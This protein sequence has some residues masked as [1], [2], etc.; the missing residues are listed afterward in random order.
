MIMKD[1][2]RLI[3]TVN[4][5][6]EEQ[7]S[8]A[9]SVRAFKPRYYH[10]S[11]E[12]WEKW[13]TRTSSRHISAKYELLQTR[14]ERP[15]SPINTLAPGLSSSPPSCTPIRQNY[16]KLETL[17]SC[18]PFLPSNLLPPLSLLPQLPLTSSWSSPSF[19]CK[20]LLRRWHVSITLSL[21][22]QVNAD[23]RLPGFRRARKMS[24]LNGQQ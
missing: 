16:R 13:P 8:E 22:F 21:T 5:L 14:V 3:I 19:V 11:R 10:E 15:E 9:H 12:G 23:L 20:S 6:K 1:F 7:V 24:P 18:F 17:L 4:D 2:L